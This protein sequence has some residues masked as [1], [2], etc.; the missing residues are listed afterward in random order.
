MSNDLTTLPP[1]IHARNSRRNSSKT[2]KNR[3]FPGIFPDVNPD[4]DNWPEPQLDPERD[5]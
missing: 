4:Y 2:G 1:N 3:A 5:C